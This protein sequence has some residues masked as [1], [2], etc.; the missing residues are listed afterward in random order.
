MGCHFYNSDEQRQIA[1]QKQPR[2]FVSMREIIFK[3]RKNQQEYVEKQEMSFD[4][5][6]S[7]A[8]NATMKK[9]TPPFLQAYH[10]LFSRV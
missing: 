7:S 2:P 6:G 10:S 5:E 1:F 4:I 3:A 9:P 8:V